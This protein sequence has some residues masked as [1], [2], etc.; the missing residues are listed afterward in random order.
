MEP[1]TYSAVVNKILPVIL[2]D[3]EDVEGNHGA[4]MGR[5]NE[6]LLFYIKSRGIPQ[7]EV[8]ELMS[9][10]RIEEIA[11]KIEDVQARNTVLEYI[12]GDTDED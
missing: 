9:R 2:C 10:A 4:T 11:Q 12:G 5:L 1:S 6:D 3:E 7:E 8:Y